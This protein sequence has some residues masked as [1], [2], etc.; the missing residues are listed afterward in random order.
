MIQAIAGTIPRRQQRM[1]EAWAEIHQHELLEDWNRL[2]AGRP[3]V[4][5]EPLR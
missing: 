3:P 5:I 1:V 2:Q 4:S